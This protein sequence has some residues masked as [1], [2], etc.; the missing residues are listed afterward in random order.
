MAV[1]IALAIGITGNRWR[2]AMF[3]RAELTVIAEKIGGRAGS[4]HRVAAL[5]LGVLLGIAAGASDALAGDGDPNATAPSDLVKQAN[6]PISSILQVR[7]QDS[8]APEFKGLNGQGNTV[9]I[10]VTM[11]LPEFRLLPVPQLSLLTLPVAVTLPGG[12]TGLGDLRL[13]NIAVLDTGPEVVWGVG[14]SLVFPT[15]STPQIG[16]GKWQAGPAA[17]IAIAPEN[18]LVGVLA[19]NPIS[20]AGDPSRPAVNALYLT[21]FAVYQLGRGWFIRSQPQMI[22][23][24]KSG[25]QVLPLDLGVGRVFTI[26]RQDV[27]LLVEPFWNI[28]HDGPAPRYGVTFGMSLL[29]PNFWRDR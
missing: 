20:F 7:L 8:Y 27:N 2:R 9:S 21:P 12:L 17:A 29:Y 24:W 10:A 18:W 16:Q 11:P 6:A 13:A 1:V 3:S 5:M 15:A 19:Q 26:G 14:A 23:N 28:S 25:K 4:M 22:F